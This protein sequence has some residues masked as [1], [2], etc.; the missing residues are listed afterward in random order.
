MA[1]G[2]G[3][4]GN[5]PASP[6]T[7]PPAYAAAWQQKMQGA[8]QVRTAVKA[9]SAVEARAGRCC[10][11]LECQKTGWCEDRVAFKPAG[12]ACFVDTD[13]C[14]PNP[15]QLP[16]FPLCQAELEE[17]KKKELMAAIQAHFKEWLQATGA[18]R[19]VCGVGRALEGRML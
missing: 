10:W 5:F 18:M 7:L 3:A 13:A 17:G 8:A 15:S 14:S 6:F 19:Q 1:V 16:S 2:E 4:S 9:V 11:G 12:A